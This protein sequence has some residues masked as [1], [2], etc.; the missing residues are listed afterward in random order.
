MEGILDYAEAAMSGAKRSRHGNNT[1]LGAAT[2]VFYPVCGSAGAVGVIAQE[3]ESKGKWK[4]GRKQT[5]LQRMMHHWRSSQNSLVLRWQALTLFNSAKAALQLSNQVNGAA[6]INFLPMYAFNLSALGFNRVLPLAGTGALANAVGFPMY[7]L[8]KNTT[9]TASTENYTWVAVPTLHGDPTGSGNPVGW[10]VEWD[11]INGSSPVNVNTY[12]W[13]WADV[14][15]NFSGAPNRPVKI[16]TGLVHF[17]CGPTRQYYDGATQT[18]DI[19][20]TTDKV[21]QTVFWDH[22]WARKVSNPIRSS[23]PPSNYLTGPPMR[24]FKHESFML[25]EQGGLNND[26]HSIQATMSRYVE[27]CKNYRI[28]NPNV[29][30]LQTKN[31]VEDQ[32]GFP[33]SAFGYVGL[34]GGSRT[35]NSSQGFYGPREKDTWLVIYADVYDQFKNAVG[36]AS[37]QY[38]DGTTNIATYSPSFDVN[39]RCKYSYN[40]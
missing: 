4:V 36:D 33:Q 29:S 37:G 21:D 13:D 12:T 34:D 19:D 35:I 2:S 20:D 24:M 23:R 40:T 38:P 26:P 16:H 1:G 17:P 30:E 11:K 14:K 3:F 27:G 25:G 6:T 22:F 28:D 8:Q 15:L 9:G 7:R 39:I 5:E 18:V 32:V 31:I 10:S